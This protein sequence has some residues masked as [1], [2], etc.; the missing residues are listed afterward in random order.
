M[1]MNKQAQG[2]TLIELMIVVAIIGILAAIALPAYQTYTQK[3]KFS[4]VINA[5]AGVKS[6]IEVCFATEADFDACGDADNNTVS[7][8]VGGSSGGE[9]VGSVVVDDTTAMITAEG[10]GAVD[11][12]TYI[13]TPTDNN[14]Q[15]VWTTSGTCADEGLCD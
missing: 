5:T 14:G 8:A 10:S 11:T 13:L 15:V 3:A 1:K 7:A 6:A 2:F 9:Y 4:E 12:I